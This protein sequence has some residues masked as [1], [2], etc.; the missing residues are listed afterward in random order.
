MR[1][2]GQQARHLARTPGRRFEDIRLLPRDRGPN[3]TA[4]SDAIFPATGAK[5]LISAVQAPRR[6][7]TR[8]RLIGTLRRAVPGRILIPGQRRLRAAVTGH[9]AHDNT[10]QP[11]QGI[12]QRVPGEEP[13]VARAALT[14]I[15]RQQ[16]RR[17]PIPGGLINEHTHAA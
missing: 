10:A 6:N 11:H 7:T 4:S 3:C 14:N 2:P 5:I 9:Q 15:D 1:G 17:K 13:D 16:T 8:Q 12:A